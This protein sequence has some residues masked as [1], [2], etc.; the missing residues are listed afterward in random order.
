MRPT[1]KTVFRKYGLALALSAIGLT[2]AAGN[3]WQPA[4]AQTDGWTQPRLVWEGRGAINAPSRVADVYGRVHAFW[5][6][7]ADE[8]GDN[9][10]MQVY[11][12]RLD[13]PTWQPNDI[14]IGAVSS[15]SLKSTMSRGG[16]ALL[17]SGNFFATSRVS[18]GA[19]AQD[20][21]GPTTNQSAYPEAGLAVAPD[22]AVWQIFGAA[23]T[24]GVYVQRLNP[25][26]GF[27]EAARLVSDPVNG[28]AA[29]D[30]TRLAFSADGT[31]H[32]VWAEYQLPNGWPPVGLY[33][34]QS[35]DGGQ[36]WSGRHKI[37]GGNF[38][39]PNVV[40]GPGQ[41]VYVAWTGVAGAG[42]KYFEESLDG[43]R[44]WQNQVVVMN[45][46]IGG[47][48]GA[49]NLAYD[50]AGNLHMVFSGNGCAWH[51]SR[52]NNVWSAPECIS[53]GVAANALIESPAMA[54]GLGNQ[55]HVLFWTD[56]RQLWYTTRVLAAAAVAAL[57]T[58]TAVVPTATAISPTI[59][60]VPSQTPLPDYGP[61]PR[62]EQATLPGWWALAAGVAPVI[63]L[64]LA[65]AGFRQ[66]RH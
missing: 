18:V 63:V 37:A 31:L 22:G 48:E 11:Y 27:W 26:T 35:K 54:L 39:Q 36:T 28:S 4:Q 13:Q 8:Q 24:N 2:A 30:G 32:A 23:G 19:S 42:L 56:R 44:T 12:T 40:A 50:S 38:N 60:P 15:S 14:F 55:L 65:V 57:P 21:T 7:A 45:Q 20:W 61:S 52:E 47:S 43:G 25:D 41:E 17:W 64:L 1:L 53:A 62:P 58:P 6:F 5:L 51:T 66:R 3:M 46:P 29:P 10:Q 34:A 59:T 9:P 33:Y 16:L 49:P